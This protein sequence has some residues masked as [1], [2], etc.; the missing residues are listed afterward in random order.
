MSLC[1][2]DSGLLDT[3]QDHGR[4]GYSALGINPGGAMDTIAASVANYLV[5]NQSSEAVIELHYP[6]ATIQFRQQVIIAISGADFSP[7]INNTPI[8]N[9]TPVIVPPDAVLQ[10]KKVRS[11][12]RAYLAVQGGLDIPL[13]LN[14]YSTHLKAKAGGYDGRALQK[15]DVIP[16]NNPIPIAVEEY[17][18][19]LPWQADTKELYGQSN[20]IRFIKGSEYDLLTDCSKTIFEGNTFIITPQSDRMGSSMNGSPLQ[21][22]EQKQMISSAVTR[23]TIQLLPN[24]QII[25]LMA[26]HQTTGGY[27]KIAH[28]ISADIPKLAQLAINTPVRFE[29]VTIKEAEGALIQQHHYLKQIQNACTFRMNEYFK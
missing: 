28:V 3:V 5:G 21:T 25:V 11:G 10:F 19:C 16:L 1:I 2:I 22:T 4:Y 18:K 7:H 17:L 6:A 8:A 24:G 15:N 26:D 27:F 9:N 14:S 29:M 23:G 20:T 12:T 13:W